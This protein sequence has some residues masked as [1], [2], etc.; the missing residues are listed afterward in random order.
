M[1]IIGGRHR[2]RELVSPSGTHTRPTADRAR[3]ALFDTLMHAPFAGRARVQDARVLDAFAGT[4]ALGLEALSRGAAQASFIDADPAA[5]A[6]IQ[7]NAKRLRELHRVRVYAADVLAP[8]R[9]PNACALVFL[10]PPYEE[11]LAAPALRALD[12]AGWIAPGALIVLESARDRDLDLPDGFTVLDQR[13]H[14][15]AL[16][17]ILEKERA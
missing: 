5:V 8:P 1:R 11:D 6:A 9:A 10:D 15:R 13:R 2:G 3:Q 17:T 16:M 14:G 4:G 12:A 7:E